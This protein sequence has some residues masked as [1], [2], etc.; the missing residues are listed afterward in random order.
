M[1]QSFSENVLKAQKTNNTQQLHRQAEIC[2]KPDPS[3]QS[4]LKTA[5]QGEFLMKQLKMYSFILKCNDIM[6]PKCFNVFL[7]QF[8]D[9]NE[10]T[11]SIIL[12]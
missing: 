1:V 4:H 9:K 12:N 5:M 11:E 3:H 7:V 6:K 2:A 10:S 8:K